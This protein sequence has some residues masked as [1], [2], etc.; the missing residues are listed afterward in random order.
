MGFFILPECKIITM[1]KHV[2]KLKLKWIIQAHNY[3]SRQLRPL[4]GLKSFMSNN[5]KPIRVQSVVGGVG[6]F[7]FVINC[8][9][10]RD[11]TLDRLL[12]VP[13]YQNI[14]SPT[15]EKRLIDIGEPLEL[16]GPEKKASTRKKL[17]VGRIKSDAF[18]HNTVLSQ[19]TIE[20]TLKLFLL[21]CF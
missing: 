2:H 1:S 13:Q 15:C 10:F 19:Y 21:L 17:V 16:C 20:S 11:F 8:Q 18:T 4:A 6:Y 14:S 5:N 3:T 12:C 7:S 9:V